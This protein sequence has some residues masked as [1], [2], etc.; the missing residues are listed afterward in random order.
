MEIEKFV[1]VYHPETFEWL[2]SAETLKE[3]SVCIDL[4]SKKSNNGARAMEPWRGL[5]L[6]PSG[7]MTAAMVTLTSPNFR[8]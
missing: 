2:I 8:F 6:I 4:H 3:S 5:Q 7:G 1:V